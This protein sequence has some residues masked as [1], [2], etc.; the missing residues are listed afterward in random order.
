MRSQ[1]DQEGDKTVISHTERDRS[2]CGG[3]RE[4]KEPPR[5]RQSVHYLGNET[6]TTNKISRKMRKQSVSLTFNTATLGAEC[7]YV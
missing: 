6:T 7:L 3:E 5:G 4:E 2:E 1:I